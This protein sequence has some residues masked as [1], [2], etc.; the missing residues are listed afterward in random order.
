M[1]GGALGSSL[2]F[3]DE[4]ANGAPAAHAQT[5]AEPTNRSA[6]SPS[7]AASKTATPAG[8]SPAATAAATVA[9][10]TT[11]PTQPPAAAG[12]GLA[13]TATPR[14][15]TA[16]LP[17]PTATKAL[18]TATR[19][20]TPIVIQIAPVPEVTAY[21]GVGY[22]VGQ[23]LQFCWQVTPENRPYTYLIRQ[24]SPVQGIVRASTQHAG[25]DDCMNGL[26]QSSDVGT[27]TV[28]IELTLDGQTA[29]AQASK[30]I[31]P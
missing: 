30:T 5:D 16:T 7:S 21:F 22:R 11:P 28:R 15:P 13:P 31:L 23:E 17:P 24:L 4:P 25:G 12:A 19:T 18:P 1:F 20:A 10:P 26:I 2:L 9:M 29:S 6:P 27:L 14:P 3:R 8:R